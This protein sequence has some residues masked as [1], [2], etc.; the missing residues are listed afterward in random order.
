MLHKNLIAVLGAIGVINNIGKA[1]AAGFFN[2]QPEPQS[3][4]AFF[5]LPGYLGGSAFGND[6]GHNDLVG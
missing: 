6:D 4:S 5:E 3:G 2:T 1:G